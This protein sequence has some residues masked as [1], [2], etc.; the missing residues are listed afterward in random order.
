MSDATDD[1]VTDRRIDSQPLDGTAFPGGHSG[2]SLSGERSDAE[3]WTQRADFDRPVLW[4][5][6]ASLRTALPRVTV[7]AV[8]VALGV[9]G[10]LW[11]RA[12]PP[13][14]TLPID[15]G[16]GPLPVWIGPLLVALAGGWVSVRRLLDLG[17]RRYALT[18]ERW[19]RSRGWWR[20]RTVDRIRLADLEAVSRAQSL[21]SR[22]LGYDHLL[23]ETTT[24]SESWR[25]ASGLRT[26]ERPHGLLLRLERSDDS[27]VDLRPAR[28]RVVPS[29]GGMDPKSVVED[30]S[31]RFRARRSGAVSQAD[32]DGEPEPVV[33]D[34]TITSTDSDGPVEFY[35]RASERPGHLYDQLETIH[36]PT[37]EFDQVRCDFAQQFVDPVEF[38]PDEFHDRLHDGRLQ[39]SAAE[40][41]AL[42][43][44]DTATRETTA[45]GL[46]SAAEASVD[47]RQLTPARQSDG[48]VLARPA[49]ADVDTDAITWDAGEEPMAML[50]LFSEVVSA[51]AEGP[52]ADGPLATLVDALA[53][54]N[55]PVAFQAAFAHEQGWTERANQRIGTI[56]AGQDDISGFDHLIKRIPDPDE[57]E[58]SDK[59]QALIADLDQKRAH[60]VYRTTL[61]ATVITEDTDEAAVERTLD[62]IGAAF[63]NLDTEYCEL[64]V[65]RA[66][67]TTSWWPTRQSAPSV[68]EQ[69]LCGANRVTDSEILLSAAELAN[70]AITPTAGQLSDHGVRRTEARP[71][72]RTAPTAPPRDRRQQY[73]TGQLIGRALD[74]NGQLLPPSLHLPVEMQPQHT[75]LADVTG[76]GKTTLLLLMALSQVEHAQGPNVIFSSKDGSLPDDFMRAYAARYGT[77]RLETDVVYL[78]LHDVQPGLSMFDID[79]LQEI[80][81]E[82]D[83]AGKAPRAA[84]VRDRVVRLEEFLNLA[85]GPEKY[86]RATTSPQVIRALTTAMYD[87]EHGL[88]N[89]RY[90][91]SVDRFGYDQLRYVAHRLWQAG[92][93]NRDPDALPAT[94]DEQ[95]RQQ[96]QHL[97][98]RDAQTFASIMGGVDTRLD[99]LV[100]DPFLRR[101]LSTTDATLDFHELIHEDTTVIV[102]VG[103]LRTKPAR[104]VVGILLT[105]LYDA[106]R[107]SSDTIRAK[108]A[109]YVANVYI[110]EGA[111]DLLPSVLSEL[112][113]RGRE[114]RLSL[115]LG[116][117]FPE[118]LQES[119]DREAYLSAVGNIG[120]HI[121]G[122]IPPD[123]TVAEAFAHDEMSPEAFRNRANSLAP[124]EW[125]VRL[126]STDR[127]SA[128]PSPFY[129]QAPPL[130]E[131]HPDGDD[132]L[133]GADERA[134]QDARR[135]M[136]EAVA[137]EYGAEESALDPSETVPDE[138]ADLLGDADGDLELALAH[139]LRS[140]QLR[141]DVRE[142]NEGVAVEVVDRQLCEHYERVDADPPETATLS[143]VRERSSLVDVDLDL[144]RD[145]TVVRLT[146][147][148]ERAVAPDTGG[149]RAAGGTGHDALV[150]AAERALTAAGF[151][152]Q[153][154]EQ[155]GSEQPDAWATHSEVEHR[156]AVE[157]EHT[158]V[159]NPRKVLANLRKAQQADAVPL[160]V[161][162]A[163]GDDGLKWARRI[164]RTLSPPV[165]EQ[166]AE[167]TRL[168][169]TD[170]PITFEG[171]ASTEGGTTAVWPVE[172]VDST[173]Q[174]WTRE[175]GAFVLTDDTG[176]EHV[177][178]SDLDDVAKS[179][180]PALA[181]HDATAD[182]W[183]VYAQGDRTMYSTADAFEAAWNRVRY[184]FVPERALPVP[185]FGP[186]TYGIV[187]LHADGPVAYRDGETEP[188]ESLCRLESAAATTSTTAGPS[189]QADNADLETASA[190]SNETIDADLVV[191]LFADALLERQPGDRIPT[192]DVYAAYREFTAS[193]GL[194]D[195]SKGWFSRRLQ[196]QLDIETTQARLDGSR[197]RCYVGV[198][199]QSDEPAPDERGQ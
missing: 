7:G 97:I 171:G 73:T 135:R 12:D 85:L 172:A 120:T 90:R 104:T 38:S 183:V 58:P 86:D 190:A 32:R 133:T 162:E 102:D 137:D 71:E 180:V 141:R 111:S 117:Q 67:A 76:G 75:L 110:D 27:P 77:E 33:F 196:A 50:E 143:A 154:I 105:C 116:V 68:S 151:D 167:C 197:T 194:P 144:D 45:E 66:S 199:L 155:D 157:A 43:G 129:V 113:T 107:A 123:R 195:E 149:T 24:R 98:G 101:M 28:V 161:V 40:V 63:S 59:E 39:C 62:R 29:H 17:S 178:V 138:V 54:A 175:D 81:A 20:W 37:H 61:G 35:Y 48:S 139:V 131:G 2:S 100:E 189:T 79:P 188:F 8:L 9:A 18:D 118:Q 159:D 187:V 174:I 78:P 44:D 83:T 82:S 103:K 93:P 182:E 119:R 127:D 186:E 92:P 168:Y 88:E 91:T 166:Q 23:V 89:G 108:P 16:V 94:S 74:N 31:R 170:R 145:A 51:D 95:A 46:P 169:P 176:A 134:Y 153:V 21:L 70:V 109:D 34:L 19:F 36:P 163:A 60:S 14:L 57:Y 13:V 198:T 99:P 193:H 15:L 10:A 11:F 6:R 164:E 191:S 115:T 122:G 87:E 158:T 64:T 26:P 42:A 177:R 30:V 140:V 72:S 1:E 80:W 112:L 125:F 126:P 130:P 69:V 114:F 192:D 179:D 185:E 106:L 165:R 156:F 53:E 55:S 121:V 41:V 56:E 96:F 132:P 146:D 181:S 22:G 128:P 52:T 147:D 65:S 136:A 184:P 124:N 25:V 150:H 49:L 5:G 152:V 47:G 4:T 173:H 3:W 84:A 160:F 148:G 142:A